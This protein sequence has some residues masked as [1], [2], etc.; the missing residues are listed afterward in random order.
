MLDTEAFDAENELDMFLEQN[1]IAQRYFPYL[2]AVILA[3][4]AAPEYDL[5]NAY[6]RMA[7][8]MQI[9]PKKAELLIRRAVYLGWEYAS[10][11]ASLL[12]SERLSPE[13][14]IGRAVQW[15]HRRREA[16]ERR[17]HR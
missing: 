2:K 5:S 10:S 13:A 14:F 9:S 16:F 11:P 15:L 3:A 7:A 6:A 12:F 8:Q 17:L 4:A 1:D